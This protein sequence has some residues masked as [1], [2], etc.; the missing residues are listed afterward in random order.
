MF[1]RACCCKRE[2]EQ[3]KRERDLS[4]ICKSRKKNGMLIKKEKKRKEK[5]QL[6]RPNGFTL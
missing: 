6:E 3:A 2:S 5:Y 1:A 4:K